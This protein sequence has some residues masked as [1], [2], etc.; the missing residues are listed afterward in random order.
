MAITRVTQNMMTRHSVDSLQTGL[1]RMAKLQEQLSTGR[2]LN[3]PSDSPTDTT[4]AMRLRD[5]LAA[6]RQYQRNAQDGLA[7]L[8]TID[9]TLRSATDHTREARDL[10]LQGANGGSVSPAAREALANTV[11][12]LRT[13]LLAA[14]NTTHLGRPVFGGITAGAAAYNADGTLAPG[15]TG[16]VQRTV[17]DGVEIRVDADPVAVFGPVGDSVFDHLEALSAALRAGDQ[18]AIRTHIGTLNVDLDR[19]TTARAE[20]GTRFAQVDTA[21]Q[22]AADTELRLKS[23]LSE[24]ENAD[25]PEVIV[26]LKMQETAYQ[27]SLAA[28][29]RVMQPSL[30]DFLR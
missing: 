19:I 29:A 7:W 25:L 17:A 26:D 24:V 15:V 20:A 22:T 3:R 18:S 30:L 23:S 28:T 16:S 5:S 9:A 4:S 8:G 14:A 21:T 1:G 10:A 11:D 27:A 2:V 13:N 6:T 12:Q